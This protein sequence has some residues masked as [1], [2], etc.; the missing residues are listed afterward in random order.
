VGA[1]Y[2]GTAE[3]AVQWAAAFGGQVL[4]DP[5]L[6]LITSRGPK[7]L[8]QMDQ[9]PDRVWVVPHLERLYLR[10]TQGPGL[11]RGLH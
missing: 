9:N 6:D 8:E 2:S 4:P 10:H 7:W 11:L 3:I 1:P 5:R